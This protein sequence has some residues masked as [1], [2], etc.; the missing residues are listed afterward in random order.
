MK[1]NIKNGKASGKHSKKVQGDIARPA[2]LS[3]MNMQKAP[4]IAPRGLGS[5]YA[6]AVGNVMQQAKEVKG[7]SHGFLGQEKKT[8]DP[9]EHA[10]SLLK[11]K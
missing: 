5:S 7:S 9:K 4:A 1:T 11:G 10:H 3:D 2:A 8:L 6:Q